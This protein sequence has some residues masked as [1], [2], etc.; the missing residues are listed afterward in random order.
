MDLGV[1]GKVAL[2]TG[3]SSGIGRAVALS[4]AREG[5]CVALAARRTELLQAAAAAAHAAGA[6]E[7]RAYAADLSDEA[8]IDK[9]LAQVRAEFGE[10][11]ILIV[12]GGGPKPGTFSQL[13]AADWDAAYALILRSALRLVQGVLPGMRGRKWGRIVAL[14]SVS[15]KQP[16]LNLALSNAL[17]VAVVGAL[18][19]LASEVAA[20]GVTVNTIATGLVETDRFRQLYDS[21]EKV[22]AAVGAIPIQRAATP[23]EFA[24]LVTFLCGEPAR[25]ITGQTISID[26]GRTSGLFG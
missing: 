10:V 24:P 3:A 18:K 25:Y 1:A 26:G 16:I 20:E 21:K 12:N 19:S 17:R 9:L 14:E 11:G 22:S 7:A 5:A 2:V 15:V 6:P 8:S 4:L 13:S 23:E